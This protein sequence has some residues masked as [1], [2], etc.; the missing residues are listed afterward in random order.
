MPSRVLFVTG[1]L[2]E[3]A[4]RRVLAEMAPPFEYE[5]AALGITVAALM[6]TDWIAR[7]VH[8]PNGV[9]LAKRIEEIALWRP[10]AGGAL[11]GTPNKFV[12]SGDPR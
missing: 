5:I 7:H 10:A 11:T 12:R 3:P 9:D 6:T 1:R 2:A 8:V 4:L